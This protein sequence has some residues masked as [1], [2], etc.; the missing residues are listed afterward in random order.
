LALYTQWHR[1]QRYQ[2][3]LVHFVDGPLTE[4]A[5]D[6]GISTTRLDAGPLLGSYNKRLL[7]LRGRDYPRIV[8]ELIRHNRALK[9]LLIERKAD[10]LHCN[11]LR[12]GM[13]CFLGGRWAGCPV[14]T[15]YRQDR[16]FGWIDRIPYFGSDGMIWV[17]RR[18]RDDFGRRHQI[19]EPVGRVIYNGRVLSDASEPTTKSELLAEFGLPDDACLVL[20]AAGFDV[21]KDHETMVR[22]AQVACH[23]EPRLHF[24]LAGT[25]VTEGEV[26]RRKIEGMVQGAGLGHRVLFLGHRT[27]IGRL[28]RGVDLVLNPAKEEALGGSLI[29]AMGYGVPCVATDTGG[30]AEIVLPDACGLLVPPEDAAGLADCTVRLLHDEGMHKEFAANARAHFERNFTARRCATETAAYFDE[31]IA[32]RRAGETRPLPARAVENGVETHPAAPA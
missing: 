28:M 7:A 20:V 18:V 21:R 6:A 3:H 27:D 22:A 4:A 26:R 31:L 1:E 12:V 25:D 23:D 30:T 17:S 16:T 2:V 29:E 32:A 14:V 10:L 19:D 15:H 9:R 5:R 8:T 13:M 24:L 11:N